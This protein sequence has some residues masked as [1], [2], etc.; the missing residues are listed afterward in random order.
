MTIGNKIDNF[1]QSIM[2]WLNDHT[3]TIC[4]VCGRVVFYKDIT[5]VIHRVSGRTELCDLCYKKIYLPYSNKD[6][7]HE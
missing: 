4:S 2:R 5:M 6:D 3:L 1:I 7:A